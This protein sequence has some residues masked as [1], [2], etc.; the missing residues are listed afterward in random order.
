MT[1]QFSVTEITTPGWNDLELARRIAAGDQ[2][3]FIALMRRYN[4][5]LYRA[6][7]SVLKAEGEVED[8]LQEAYLRAYGCIG[9]FRGE[10]RLSTWLVRIVLNEA[11]ARVRRVNGAAG[12]FPAVDSAATPEIPEHYAQ[13]TEMRRL[14][15]ARIDAL[16]DT[17]RRVFVLRALE[18]LPVDDVAAALGIPQAMVRMRFFR[19]KRLLRK[20]L[21]R[22]IELPLARVFPFAGRRC[23]GTVAAVLA[24]VATMRP[25]VA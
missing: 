21:A 17:L 5:M 23:A 19:A 1:R 20:A 6:A 13:R 8:A 25:G 9:Q 18:E 24:R 15:Q 11:L 10:A 3:A 4:R 16:P 2:A 12:L 22:D 14:L 7:R